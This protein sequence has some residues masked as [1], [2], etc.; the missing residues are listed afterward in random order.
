MA[1]CGYTLVTCQ[2]CA[3]SDRLY[4]A[5]GHLSKTV[6]PPLPPPG[7]ATVWTDSGL[8]GAQTPLHAPGL[9]QHMVCG[10]VASVASGRW[11]QSTGQEAILWPRPAQAFYCGQQQTVASPSLGDVLLLLCKEGAS[12]GS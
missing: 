9:G 3:T 7:L 1:H 2:Q 10:G 4:A 12:P 5:Q 6:L 8:Y 11:G